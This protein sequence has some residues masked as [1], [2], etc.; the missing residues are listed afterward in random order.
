MLELEIYVIIDLLE[1]AL[2]FFN[3]NLTSL[4]FYELVFVFVSTHQMH[5]R[6]FVQDHDS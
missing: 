2:E 4:C 6:K 1:R 5:S 3:I